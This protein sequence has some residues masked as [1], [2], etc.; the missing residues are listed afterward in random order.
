MNENPAPSPEKTVTIDSRQLARLW[1]FT[2]LSIVLNVVILAALLI[3]AVCRH[4]NHKRHHKFAGGPGFGP[5]QCMA[6][7]QEFGRGFHHFRGQGWGGPGGMGGCP[8][9]G[10]CPMMG[11][12]GGPNMMSGGMPGMPGMGDPGMMDKREWKAW[13][14]PDPAK[15]SDMILN[16]LSSQLTLT[17][18]EKTKVKAIL[19]D[20]AA[21]MQKDMDAQKAAR[22][23]AMTDTKAKIRAVLTPDQQ[24]QFDAL[25]MPGNKQGPPPPAGK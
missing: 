6:G 9:M 4:E 3:G 5:M 23:K 10:E 12:N 16:H 25:P 1:N 2:I 22:E 14:K 8:M 13:K 21:Q 7:P 17:D 19:Q 11:N 20:Q 18:D 24:K 15:M